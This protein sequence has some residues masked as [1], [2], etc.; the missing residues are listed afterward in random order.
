L[1]AGISGSVVCA[2][3][4]LSRSRLSLIE[5]GYVLASDG[6]LVRINAALDQLI[7]TKSVIEK[8][9]ASMGW[10]VQEIR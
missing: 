1:A 6:E 3:V 10:P 8:V 4:G 2:K 9:A 5:R 7:Q